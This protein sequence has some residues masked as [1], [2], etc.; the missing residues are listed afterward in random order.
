MLLHFRDEV[1]GTLNVWSKALAGLVL[2]MLGMALLMPSVVAV[3]KAPNVALV[4]ADGVPF[5]IT[6]YS[7]N[8]KVVMLDFM[9]LTCE[10]CKVLAKD[11]KKLYDQDLEDFEI[12]SVDTFVLDTDEGLKQYAADHDYNWRFSK[13]T[14]TADTQLAYGIFENPTIV[15]I[16]RDGYVTYKKSG[17][18][19]LEELED[20]VDR[21]LT[22]EAEPI[23]VV[24]LGLIAFAFLAGLAAFFSP[25][26]FPLLP[27]YITY[28]FKVGADA[29]K[30]KT[31]QAAKDGIVHKGPTFGNQVK[32]GL[33]LGSI[34]GLGIV[35]VYFII[36]VIVIGALAV[37]VALTG[38]AITYLK[39]IVGTILI[40]MGFLT[41]FDVAINT[42]YITA[43]FRR[44]KEKIRPRKG[45]QKPTFNNAG[46]FLYGV[47]YGSASAS[48]SAPIFIALAVT[49]VA[50]GNPQDA[51]ITFVVFL[52][53]LWLLMAV[54]SVVLTASEEKV[55]SGMMRYYIWIKRV[56]GVVFMIAGAYLLW[57]FLEAEGYIN[58]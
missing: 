40:V 25:C 3:D 57:L 46:L 8:N 11:L 4:D 44:L 23:D 42:G 49:A 32:T 17:I 26:S 54:V 15:I 34:A 13:D 1:G 45:P 39:P 16:D 6:D 22:G 35:L 5:N 29:E 31:E 41:V 52:F 24:Q 21:A 56:T 37:G 47:G 53:S 20:E 33:R 18:L 12:L 58:L 30:R 27:G 2:I 55:K 9:F 19:S 50:T 28:Y 51:V 43:P 10:P 48:C 14:E 7:D 36:G 38:G